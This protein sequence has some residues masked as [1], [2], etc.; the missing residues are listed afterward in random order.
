LGFGLGYTPGAWYGNGHLAGCLDE[1]MR[2][3]YQFLSLVRTSGNLNFLLMSN[4]ASHVPGIDLADL[5]ASPSLTRG[6][7]TTETKGLPDMVS[8]GFHFGTSLS[9]ADTPGQAHNLE[10]CAGSFAPPKQPKSNRV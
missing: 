10:A 9:G 7:F 8:V 2:T 3:A 4:I 6:L 5:D 1:N